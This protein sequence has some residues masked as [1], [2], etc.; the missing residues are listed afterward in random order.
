MSL[1][2]PQN[3]SKNAY[4]TFLFKDGGYLPGILLI[5]HK[6]REISDRDTK[7]ICLHTNDVEQSMLEAIATIYDDVQS[8]EYLR[9]GKNRVG[10]QTPLPFM[11]TRFRFL[12]T[13]QIDKVLVFDADMLPLANYDGLFELDA[14]AG[15]I[16]ESKENMKGDNHSTDKLDKWEWHDKYEPLYGQGKRLPKDITDKPIL[17]PEINMGINGGL[18]LL[19]PSDADFEAFSSWCRQPDNQAAIEKMPWPDMQAI[20]AF[21]SGKWTN[22][23]AKYLGLYGY[24][25]ISSLNGIHFIGPKPWQWRAKGFA[26]RLNNYPDYKLWAD[27]YLKMCEQRPELLKYKQLANLKQQIEANIT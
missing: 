9:F 26:Y 17:Q 13:K 25:N 2:S 16:N 1:K 7:L 14:P 4:G 3:N 12:Q 10:R 18:M 15:V 8:V 21:Y 11:F 20:T 22:I 24:P 5:A 6:L 19:Q 23:D 27:E